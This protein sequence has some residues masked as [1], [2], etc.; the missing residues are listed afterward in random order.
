MIDSVDWL[1]GQ[2]NSAATCGVRTCSIDATTT[3]GSNSMGGDDTGVVPIADGKCLPQDRVDV[4]GE[5]GVA[6]SLCRIER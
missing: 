2:S 3:C 6:H 4:G 1:A 5:G